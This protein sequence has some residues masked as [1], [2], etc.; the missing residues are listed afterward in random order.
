MVLES[1][2]DTISKVFRERNLVHHRLE[3]HNNED[4][5]L[6]LVVGLISENDL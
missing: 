6:C 4:M 2:G 1:S 3:F 5:S